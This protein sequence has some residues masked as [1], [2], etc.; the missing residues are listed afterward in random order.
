MIIRVKII[1][2]SSK[3]QITEM[4]DK[5]LKIKTTA[6]PVDG[7][8][9]EALIKLLSKHLDIVKSKIKIKNGLTSRNKI[10]EIL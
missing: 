1:P 3:N 5:S 10:V 2:R 8:A 9:N 6:A 7:E 4:P